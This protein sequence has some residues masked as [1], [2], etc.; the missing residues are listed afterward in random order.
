[1]AEV[2]EFL[3]NFLSNDIHRNT[4]PGKVKNLHT[5]FVDIKGDGNPDD[6]YFLYGRS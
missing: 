5:I 3:V 4:E 6:Y 2:G 1:M